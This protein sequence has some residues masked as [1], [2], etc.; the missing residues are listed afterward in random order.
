MGLAEQAYFLLE[1]RFIKAI[2]MP[3]DKLSENQLCREF[4][5]SRTP[6]RQALS[7]FIENDFITSVDKKGI[8]VKPISKQYFFDCIDLIVILEN[9]MLHILLKQTQ[10]LPIARLESY[11]A[12]QQQAHAQND[13]YTYLRAHFDFRLA[14]FA[15]TQ[16][17]ALTKAYSQ[18][19]NDLIRIAMVIWRKT[20]NEPHNSSIEADQKLLQLLQH[21]PA[22]LQDFSAYTTIFHTSK[23]QLYDLHLQPPDFIQ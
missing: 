17:K 8:F 19:V 10:P 22:T 3:N 2:Y 5:M 14:L 12:L 20:K 16:N 11:I 23:K 6:I 9:A 18:T 4:N 15:C 21:P 1:E 13:Y 7:K